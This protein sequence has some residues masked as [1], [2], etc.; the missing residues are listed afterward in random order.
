MSVTFSVSCEEKVDEDTLYTF[1]MDRVRKD[2]SGRLSDLISS[3]YGGD[4]GYHFYEE[5]AINK[6]AGRTYG[7]TINEW[8][9]IFRRFGNVE[10]DSGESY[11]FNVTHP[12]GGEIMLSVWP[13]KDVDKYEVQMSNG[14]AHTILKLLGL[15]K[16]ES[17]E[18]QLGNEDSELSR[19]FGGGISDT[20]WY[21][22][23]IRP[24][25]LLSAIDSVNGKMNLIQEFTR[26]P[27]QYSE[28]K[29][30]ENL[31][32]E[33]DIINI[34][35]SFGERDPNQ[36]GSGV[37]IYGGGIDSEYILRQLSALERLAAYALTNE[38]NVVWG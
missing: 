4:I 21:S 16:G 8:V 33:P 3:E 35:K 1:S 17:I 2:P 15:V 18:N 11:V 10:I 30:I 5:E 12:D 32:S 38:C 6:R 23:S 14:N 9:S 31:D 29:G 27:Y 25:D 20:D 19:V 36:S 7:K 22:G 37:K 34:L 26:S 28:E 24:S 13:I